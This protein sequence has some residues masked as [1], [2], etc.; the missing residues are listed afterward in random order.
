MHLISEEQLD[1][2]WRL[3]NRSGRTI[4]KLR[5]FETS[6]A[7]SGSPILTGALAWLDCR[8]ESQMDTG[9]RTVFLA[10]VLAGKLLRDAAPLTFKRLLEVA[11]AKKLQAMKL[12]VEHDAAHDREAIAAWRKRQ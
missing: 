10:E 5:G 3:G 2:V 11:P 12:A 9:D 7:A 8:V 4:D 6:E 1:W